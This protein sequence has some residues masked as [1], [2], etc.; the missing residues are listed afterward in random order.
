MRLGCSSIRLLLLLSRVALL[1]L[2]V[3]GGREVS[4]F[5][6]SLLNKEKTKQAA[7]IGVQAAIGVRAR[8]G[9]WQRVSPNRYQK[10]GKS[11]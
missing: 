9:V 3:P 5:L 10:S 7:A 1:Q 6:I 8:V 2:E 11:N 4:R